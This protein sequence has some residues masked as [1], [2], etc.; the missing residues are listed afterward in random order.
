MD[1]H[2]ISAALFVTLQRVAAEFEPQDLC[3]TGPLRDP[4]ALARYSPGK[5]SGYAR[6]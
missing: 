3:D 2:G 5:F 6:R 4:V 1:E